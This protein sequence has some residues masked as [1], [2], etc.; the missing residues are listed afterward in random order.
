MNFDFCVKSLGSDSKSHELD[1]DGLGL[2]AVKLLDANYTG[3]I[4]YIK[5]LQ[6]QISE[7]R[8]LKALSLCLRVYNFLDIKELIPVYKAKRH[9]DAGMLVS[10]VLT[11]EETCDTQVSRTKG[12]VPPLTKHNADIYQLS[13][14]AL[15]I[16]AI[17][18]ERAKGM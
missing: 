4:E 6:K 15:K 9:A 13:G 11:N 18:R 10:A 2:I 17:L 7:P 3:T 8:L 5:Q 14:I 1:L 16:V 12:M